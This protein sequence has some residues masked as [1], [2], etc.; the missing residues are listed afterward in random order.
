MGAVRL[1][2]ELYVNEQQKYRVESDPIYDRKSKSDLVIHHIS[3]VSSAVSGGAKIILL[4]DKVK[5]GDI[6]VQFYEITDDGEHVWAAIDKKDLYVHHQT[7]I[8]FKTPKYHDLGIGEPVKT[9]M[10]LVRPSDGIISE[11]L[12]FE[13]T[14]MPSSKCISTINWFSLILIVFCVLG[15]PASKTRKKN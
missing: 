7:A 2:F 13:F 9:Y 4:C 10:R 1:A 8:L 15:R 5:K 14:P 11:P 6:M 12:I 3:S